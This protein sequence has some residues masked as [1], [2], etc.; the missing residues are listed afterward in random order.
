MDKGSGTRDWI[1]KSLFAITDR[2]YISGRVVGFVGAAHGRENGVAITAPLHSR[3]CSRPRVAP[4]GLKGIR[5][6]FATV[7]RSYELSLLLI[8]LLTLPI[9]ARPCICGFSI[10]ITLPISFMDEAPVSAMAASIICW[11]SASSSAFGR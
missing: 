3:V 4:T 6:L 7:G 8:W 2:S 9:S 5:V 10:P 1:D 11:I